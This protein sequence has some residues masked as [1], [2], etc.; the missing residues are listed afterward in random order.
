MADRDEFADVAAEVI[1]EVDDRVILNVG[2]RAEGDLI[3]VAA[4]GGVVP[5]AGFLVDRDA[6]DHIGTGG[7]ESAFVDLGMKGREG[8]NGHRK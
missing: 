6:A 5:H 1:G 3:D 7:N 8:F 2:A 4:K